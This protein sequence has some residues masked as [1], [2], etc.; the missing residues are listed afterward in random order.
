MSGWKSSRPCPLQWDTQDLLAASRE[1]LTY[2]NLC[3][4]MWITTSSQTLNCKLSFFEHTIYMCMHVYMITWD[5]CCFS[6]QFMDLPK[7]LMSCWAS[8]M[9]RK[10]AGLVSQEPWIHSVISDFGSNKSLAQSM[11]KQTY[12]TVVFAVLE[13]LFRQR[14]IRSPGLNPISQLYP[15]AFRQSHVCPPKQTCEGHTGNNHMC[16]DAAI[17]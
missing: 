4:G 15:I 2:R 3:I 5:R 1:L 17:I 14:T 12:L 8:R 6:F 7:R 10:K 13:M 9:Q 16:P 11:Q